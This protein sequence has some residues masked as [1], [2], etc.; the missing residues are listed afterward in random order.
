MIH[1]SSSPRLDYCNFHILECPRGI[2]INTCWYRKQ[3]WVSGEKG[4]YLPIW[5]ALTALGEGL[6]GSWLGKVILP[7]G[8]SMPL[9]S[10]DWTA[11]KVFA[12]QGLCIC[13]RDAMSRRPEHTDGSALKMAH[14]FPL[15]CLGRR[16]TNSTWGAIFSQIARI[17]IT[18]LGG[19]VGS[20]RRSH[21][22]WNH[23]LTLSLSNLF[24]LFLSKWT[25][26]AFWAVLLVPG[27]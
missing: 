24:H 13:M 21:C 10:P 12:G 5:L 19:G 20:E 2:W 6:S 26:V 11:S 17:L 25:S 27:D 15:G 18:D 8:F 1:A 4:L 9:S 22:Q 23:V 3:D 14:S 7:L 16:W